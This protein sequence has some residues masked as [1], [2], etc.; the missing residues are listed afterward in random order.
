MNSNLGIIGGIFILGMIGIVI[1][2][3]DEGWKK[4]LLMEFEMKWN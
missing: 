1:F 2:M 4:F 3:L